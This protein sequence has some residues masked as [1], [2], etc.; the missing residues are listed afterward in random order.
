MAPTLIMVRTD[1]G[2][3]IEASSNDNYDADLERPKPF[4]DRKEELNFEPFKDHNAQEK[5]K[6]KG[7]YDYGYGYHAKGK[8]PL[9]DA[10]DSFEV[11][12][13]SPLQLNV[14][15]DAPPPAFSESQQ[16]S[17]SVLIASGPPARQNEKGQLGT[18]DEGLVILN[19]PT[20][21]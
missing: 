19:P 9:R 13:L 21:E 8:A 11:H 4:T 20:V 1:L 6:L 15:S 7:E 5:S 17:S 18:N 2:I 3:S 10:H 12:P 14:D 16:S